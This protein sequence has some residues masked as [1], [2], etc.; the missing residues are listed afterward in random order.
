VL[1]NS[2]S[3]LLFFLPAALAGYFLLG[4]VRLS[5]GAGWLALASL[6]FYG[7]WDPRYVPLLLASI[8]F[9][10]FSGVTIGRMRGAGHRYTRLALVVAVAADLSLLGYFKYADFFI[11]TV[12]VLA[13]MD[14]GLLKIVLPLGVSFFTFTQIAFL[15]DAYAGHAKD[16][17]FVHYALF[18]TYFPHLI[19]G[20]ILHHKEMIPQF[21][22]A[23]NYRPRRENFEV[24]LTIFAIGLAKKVL[25]AD[26]LAPHVAAVFNAPGE[27]SLF[28]VWGGVLAYAFQL[29]FDFSGYSCMAIGLSRL[30]GIQLPINFNSPYKA[31]NITDFW[32]R[33][34]MTLSRFLRDY[35]YVPL[36][37]NRKGPARRYANLLTTMVLGGLWHGAGWT[38][39]LWGALHGIYLVVNHAWLAVKPNL[40]LPSWPRINTVCAVL[41]TFVAVCFAWVYFRAPDL[42]AANRIVLGMIG[43]HGVGLPAAIGD[44]LGTLR[45]AL[46]SLGVHFYL[47]GGGR[48]VQ[49]YLWVA[50]GALLA[51]GFPNTQ[52][53]LRHYEPGLGVR[54]SLASVSRVVWR[55]TARWAAA[56]GILAAACVLA[57]DRP[58]EFLYFQ[59]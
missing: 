18:V 31:C 28:V 41:I 2:Y 15:A 54:E 51:F 44:R 10:Y 35:L 24:G 47:G 9:N 49:T 6:F 43:A 27:S 59:F 40:P 22:V 1:F 32:R 46:E 52:Q 17:R 16:Y 5:W 48:F 12:N 3:F 58:A 42:A 37:G 50:L 25:I 21:D 55:P 4:R 30:F 39:V 14:L 11:G 33:W 19:A 53:I 34:H 36:G 20:P 13:G 26:S 8:V 45:P 56:I 7:W 23:A 38:F 29:Y 57:L